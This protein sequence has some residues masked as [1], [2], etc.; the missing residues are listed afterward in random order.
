MT[1]EDE[2]KPFL[3]NS[4]SNL[5]KVFKKASKECSQSYLN[6]LVW[7]GSK[8]NAISI[9]QFVS[10]EIKDHLLMLFNPNPKYKFGFIYNTKNVH[11]FNDL[12][13][14]MFLF[15]SLEELKYL[16]DLFSFLLRKDKKGTQI[17][18][19]GFMNFFVTM[20][21]CTNVIEATDII[22]YSKIKDLINKLR[23]NIKF[24]FLN[25]RDIDIIK[26]TKLKL[27]NKSTSRY[28]IKKRRK[29]KRKQNKKSV[30]N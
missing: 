10:F 18:N 17:W 25:D 28:K 23:N 1:F 22:L 14:F 19:Q 8:E 6:S 21:T 20:K 24:K 11:L 2:N 9:L 26:I 16:V 29:R 5:L 27:H 13:D 30:L 12:A 15:F 7:E 4:L 3:Q